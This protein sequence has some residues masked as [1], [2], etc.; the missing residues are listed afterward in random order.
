[1]QFKLC[2]LCEADE[3]RFCCDCHEFNL[4]RYWQD[5]AQLEDG[6]NSRW[7]DDFNFVR[8][9]PDRTPMGTDFALVKL[10]HQN[11][12]LGLIHIAGSIPGEDLPKNV[13]HKLGLRMVFIQDA[14]LFDP[15]EELIRDYWLQMGPPVMDVFVREELDVDR[16]VARVA[17]SRK[18]GKPNFLLWV[19]SAGGNINAFELVHHSDGIDSMQD[20]IAT[21][22]R[23]SRR[24]CNE[25]IRPTFD[26][27]FFLRYFLYTQVL[28][29]L[30]GVRPAIEDSIQK[31]IAEFQ[32]WYHP[33]QLGRLPW[34]E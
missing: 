6:E 8:Y 10:F 14:R 7:K 27:L 29:S 5:F 21:T 1:M 23:W 28:Q 11:T 13:V 18:L 9:V 22:E 26:L 30:S 24:S 31:V 34:P 15:R 2:S 25:I 4:L 19:C 12:Y 33:M 17:Y 16:F 3:T 32:S 20:Y